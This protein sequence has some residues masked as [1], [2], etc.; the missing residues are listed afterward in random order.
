MRSPII[1]QPPPASA[2]QITS[3]LPFGLPMSTDTNGALLNSKSLFNNDYQSSSNLP[4]IDNLIFTPT[5]HLDSMQSMQL[6]ESN[7]T[8]SF[9]KWFKKDLKKNLI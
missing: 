9:R 6:S 5:D 7:P 8:Y 2:N 1:S 4:S 3:N